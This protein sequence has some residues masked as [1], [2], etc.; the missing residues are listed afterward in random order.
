[1]AIIMI[2]ELIMLDDFFTRALIAGIGIALVTGPMGCFIVWR[3]MSYFGDTLA[4]AALLGVALALLLQ[5]NV[6]LAVFS[7]GLLISI[8]LLLLQR[9]QNYSSDS[10]LGLMSHSALALG[11]VAL[12]F[13]T[14]VR[15]DMTG[16]LFGDILSVSKS[17]IALVWIGGAVV[18]LALF[19]IWRSLFAA[20]VSEDLSH[21]EN[22]KPARA[23][24]VLIVLLAAVIALSMKIVGVLLISALLIIPATAARRWSSGP[25]QMAALAALI[26]VCAVTGGLFS[27][28]QWDTPA[29]PSIVVVAL[30]PFLIGLLPF[31][32]PEKESHRNP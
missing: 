19:T 20:T 12:A 5:T 4:H 22:L 30:L 27:S 25:E 1:M 7:T 17:D 28:L 31:K 13:M 15:F 24:T 11:L 9:N 2:T 14:W 10:L 21:A 32:M 8:A 18:L 26:G 16:L 3:R 6:I 29:G 23:N